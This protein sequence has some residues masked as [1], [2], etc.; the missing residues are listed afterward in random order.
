[1]PDPDLPDL[2]AVA[3]IARL[4]SFRRAAAELN[5]SVSSLSQRL[6]DMESRLGVRLLNRTTRSVAP[7]EAGEQLLARL[8][9]ALQDVTNALE[10][11]SHRG[12]APSGRLRINAPPPA[13]H[14]VLAP[15]VRAFLAR[16]PA[17]TLEVISEASLIDIVGD[18]FDA[19][20]RY[21]EDLA[22]DMIAIPLGAP[23]R[24]VVVGTPGLIARYGKP[25]HPA[26]LLDRP[27]L[28]VR[29]A[30][31]RH[32]R[33]VFERDDK[34]VSIM[35]EGVFSSNDPTLLL[36]AAMDGVG[37]L[38][39]FE[40]YVRAAID[41]GQ[42][43]TVLDDWLPYFPGPFLYYPSRRQ[44]PSALAAFIAFVAEWRSGISRAG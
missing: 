36:Q 24:Y 2:A 10:A 17:I 12:Q 23:E 25:M 39:S 14:L 31:R 11:V 32:L 20:V 27:C 13:V 3:T 30:N 29:F 19:G 42:L 22:Q 34:T 35:P 44:P 33:W 9:P 41:A 40:G 4:R 8:V 18:G 21:G 43:V 28:G 16:Y 6:R 7:T 1:M 38:A 15:M 37:F 5:V 26:D